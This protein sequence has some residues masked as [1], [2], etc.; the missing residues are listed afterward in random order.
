M[1]GE[2]GADKSV[3]WYYDQVAET[4]DQT[5]GAGRQNAYFASQLRQQVRQLLGDGKRFARALE[6]GAGTGAYIDVT[7]PLFG[8]L[9]VSDVSEGMLAVLAR[10][11]EMLEL[12]N[13]V[14]AH[15][16]ACE[17]TSIPDASVDI[18]YSIGLLETVGDLDRLF[19]SIRRVLKPAG[20]VAGIT[21]NGACPWYALRRRLEGGER[22]GR[23]DHLPTADDIGRSLQKTGFVAPEFTFWGGVPPGLQSRPLTAL[24]RMG[25]RAVTDTR[26]ASLLGVL[27][28]RALKAGASR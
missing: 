28:F 10:R 24:L 14:S 7:A 23:R 3:A 16:D 13:V 27:S 17:L 26:L 1:T 22:H 8:E 25:E 11:V 20:V 21:S 5:H 15:E 2:S 12:T 9:I 19:A 4:W 6:L 18:A